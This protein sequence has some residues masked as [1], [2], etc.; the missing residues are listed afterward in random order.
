VEDL[1]LASGIPVNCAHTRIVATDS[2]KPHPKNPYIH[3]DEQVRLI[4]VSIVRSG[5]NDHIDVSARSGTIV[6]GEGR[7]LAA[8]GAG[9]TEVP[10]DEMRFATE[11]EELVWLIGH[12]RTAEIK[13]TDF[14][15]LKDLLVDLDRGEIDMDVTGYSEADLHNLLAIVPEAPHPAE[16]EGKVRT[17]TCPG[18]GLT[19]DLDAPAAAL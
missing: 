1:I 10:I 3:P 15:A 9:L 2:L 13:K 14:N 7:W 8:K 11:D 6:A 5:W 17:A 12:N 16:P 19:F 4:A 18:C